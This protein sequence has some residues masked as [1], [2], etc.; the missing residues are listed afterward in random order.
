MLIVDLSEKVGYNLNELIQSNMNKFLWYLD[1]NNEIFHSC[2]EFIILN[3]SHQSTEKETLENRIG[4]SGYK[5]RT[6]SRDLA[7]SELQLVTGI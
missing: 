5:K 6:H 3:H 4:T 7:E 1:S 2:T